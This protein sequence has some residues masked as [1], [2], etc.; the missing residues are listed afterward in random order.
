V[1]T[2]APA[3]VTSER[4]VDLAAN[5]VISDSVSALLYAS[6]PSTDGVYGN[7]IVAIDPA[8]GQITKSVFV[9]SEPEIMAVSDDGQYLYVSLRGSSSVRR[10][11]LATFTAGLEFAL[12]NGSIVEEM[13]VVPGSPRKVVLSKR[14][15]C[16]S[17]RHEGVFVYDDGV[18]QGTST[19]GHTG[20][21]AIAFSG[22]SATFLYGYNNETTDFGFRT[23]VIDAS[24]IRVTHTTGGLIGSFYTRIM[25][26]GGRVYSTNG[27]IIDPELRVRTGGFSGTGLDGTTGLHVDP[28]LGRVF[29]LTSGIIRAFD[30]N[31]MQEIGAINA[32]GT[33]GD[34][35]AVARLRLARW[36]VD[37]LA[38]RAGTKVYILRTTLAAP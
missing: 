32:P 17:P 30:I 12:G 10:V 37:G 5:D 8:T 38:Y 27:A 18:Q 9:G 23:M 21:N 26:G 19:P 3:A 1:R 2:L 25:G 14:N 4:A 20:S 28:A 13:L 7:T 16:C 6:V 35:P 31:T 36:G 15:V 24:G 29:F 33:I 34:H 22:R 11:N